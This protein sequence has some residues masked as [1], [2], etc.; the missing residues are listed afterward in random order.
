MTFGKWKSDNRLPV[1]LMALMGLL[2]ILYLYDLV[3]DFTTP[4]QLPLPTQTRLEPLAQISQWHMFG[5]YNDS[6]ANLP[7]TQLQLTLEGV[8]LSL[9]KNTPSYAIISSPNKPAK[10][11]KVGDTIP[12]NAKLQKIL[13]TE[14]VINYQGILQ[15]LKL[16]TPQLMLDNSEPDDS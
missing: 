2:L 8:L 9:D 5:E 4:E 11:Y 12:G 14:V 1:A 6:L 10:V 16:P 15:S 3:T 7:E 13:K